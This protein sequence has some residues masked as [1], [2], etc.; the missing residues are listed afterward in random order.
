MG[1]KEHKRGAPKSLR[2]GIL[3][4]STTRS[5]GGDKSG[6]WINRH[7]QR[8]GHTVVAHEMLPDNQFT[9][10]KKVADI[11]ITQTADILIINGGTGL[12]P[13][14]VTIE[15]VKPMFRKELTAFSM[16]FTQLSFESIDSAA[17]VSR[18]TAGIIHNTA[19]FCLPGSI[20]AC[21]LAC[22]AL[23]FPEAGH[24]AAHMRAE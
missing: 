14:D 7:A 16:A 23:I 3:T 18:A 8:E 12:S 20:N 15:A 6:H 9:I 24:I 21:K 1:H 11:A 17:I 22:K 19:V 5:L 10:A 2:V 4:V 13:S